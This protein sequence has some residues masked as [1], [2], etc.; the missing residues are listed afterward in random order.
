MCMQS[1]KLVESL[2]IFKQKRGLLCEVYYDDEND[3]VVLYLHFMND[4]AA[5]E[6]DKGVMNPRKTSYCDLFTFRQQQIA[7]KWSV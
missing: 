3:D 4:L 5:T 6:I 7:E 1:I 2:L